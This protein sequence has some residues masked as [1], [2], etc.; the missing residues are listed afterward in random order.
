[1]EPRNAWTLYMRSLVRRKS[2]DAT[3][4]DADRSAALAIAPRIG[5]RAAKLGL[6]K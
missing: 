3:G 2:G 6:D 5:E 4:A 1:V